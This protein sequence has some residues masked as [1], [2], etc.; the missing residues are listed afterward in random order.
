ME[1]VLQIVRDYG[2]SLQYDAITIE[3]KLQ[4]LIGMMSSEQRAQD[5]TARRG[6]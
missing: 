6:Y 1:E 5:Q 3:E 4:E 2:P